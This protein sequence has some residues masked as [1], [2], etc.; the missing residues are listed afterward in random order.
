M[1]THALQPDDP[2]LDELLDQALAAPLM[3]PSLVDD[4]ITA[5][6]PLL[7]SR[8]SRLL[9]A[10]L[11]AEVPGEALTDRILR[12]TGPALYRRRHPV[13]GFLGSTPSYRIAAGI[14]L[15]ATMGILLTFVSIAHNARELVR[16]ETELAGLSGLAAASDIAMDQ[17]IG[18]L[19][20]QLQSLQTSIAW[21][22]QRIIHDDVTPWSVNAP[23]SDASWLF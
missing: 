1:D 16:I 4:I 10:A 12:A 18:R 15:A 3:R 2:H 9:D 6:T 19:E 8:T 13:I 23:V 17:E 20:E 21:D 14:L 22:A 7:G 5:S 11:A